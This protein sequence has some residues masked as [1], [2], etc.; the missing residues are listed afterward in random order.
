ME[1]LFEI[2]TKNSNEAKHYGA[3]SIEVLEGLEPVRKRPGMYIGGTDAVAM[4]HLITEVFDNAMDE[5]VAGYANKINITVKADNVIEISDN[6]RGIPVDKHP[7]FPDKSALEVILTTLHS[8]GK[9]SGKAYQTAGGLHGVGISVVNALSEF[10]NVE[11][12]RGGFQYEIGFSKGHK[13]KDLAATAVKSN[14]SGTKVIFK[15]D[16]SIFEEGLNFD[17]KKIYS[18]AKSKAYLHKGVK[19]NFAIDPEIYNENLAVPIK[20]EICYPN[21]LIDYITDH[22]KDMNCVIDDF[23][24]GQHALPQD[25]G[26]LEWCVAFLEDHNRIDS[27]CNTIVTPQGGSH[28]S[29]FKL[30]LIKSVKE[31]A[32]KSGVKKFEQISADDVTQ[33]AYI[34]I[35]LFFKEPQFHGQTKEK[36]VNRE[37]T[38][39]VEDIVKD[40]FEHFLFENLSNSKSLIEFFLAK[41]ESRLKLNDFVKVNRKSLTQKLRLP[42]K[43]TDCS[44][45]DKEGTEIFLV[46]GDSAGGSA[47]QARNRETQAILPLKGKILNVASSSKEKIVKNQEI[48]DLLTALG[49][50]NGSLYDESNLRYDKVI[51]MTD[52]DVDGSHIASLL[53]TF[54]FQ[55]MKDLIK[56]GHLYLA[57]PPLFRISNGIESYYVNSQE[58][59]DKIIKDLESRSKKRVDIGRFK[60]LGEMTPS[61]LKETTMDPKKRRLYKVMLDEHSF[62][63]AAF[64]VDSLMGRKPELRLKFIQENAFLANK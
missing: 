11:V 36:L 63:N 13:V 15:P 4:H 34:I 49:C 45:D 53:M 30:G 18:L 48:K 7:K 24:S 51:I 28:V 12:L 1:D 57:Y 50:M 38:K 3:E 25:K 5:A 58:E 19:V 17:L 35:S 55:E 14:K 29:G 54:F 23:F 27:F 33:S 42:G 60:G 20:H 41:S 59:R 39:M 44:S 43:L 46:E 56:N 32:K 47:K 64:K 8:G 6:G 10:T 62:D 16:F 52:A 22:I 31:Y 2:S 40:H 9:F 37:V 26:R 21:G 61:Q